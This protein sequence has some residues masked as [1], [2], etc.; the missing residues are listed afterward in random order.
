VVRRV[1]L[2]TGV[3]DTVVGTGTQG[4]GGDGGP[5]V[6]AQLNR[7]FGVAFDLNGALYVSDTFNGRIRKVET[8]FSQPDHNHSALP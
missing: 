6:N 7:P 1:N 8:E 2:T 3:I 4:Y 5:A